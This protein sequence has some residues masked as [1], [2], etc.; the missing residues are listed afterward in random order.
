M[1]KIK[2]P[3]Y[4]REI[5]FDRYPKGTIV[6][7]TVRYSQQFRARFWVASRLINLAVRILGA[8]PEVKNGT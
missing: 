1:T 8:V 7:V 2:V 4:P 3:V 6:E 5:V